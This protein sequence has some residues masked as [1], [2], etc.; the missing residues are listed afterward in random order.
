M[1]IYIM[2]KK[3]LRLGLILASVFFV[4]HSFAEE[5]I[6]TN[7]AIDLKKS[8]QTDRKVQSQPLNQSARTAFI[9]PQTGELRSQTNTTPL[10]NQQTIQKRL[11]PVKYINYANGTVGA[12]LNGRFRTNLVTTIGCNGK[13]ET[14]H[15]KDLPDEAITCEDK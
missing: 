7:S 9:D 14:K 10:D 1:Q 5:E 6:D 4:S 11:P 15:M 8:V 12:K 2:N 3:I 13:L